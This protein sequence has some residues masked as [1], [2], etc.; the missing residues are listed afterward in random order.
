M[1]E[2]MR[3]KLSLCKD[4]LNAFAKKLKAPS[5]IIK[6]TQG[7]GV[8]EIVLILIIIVGL[9]V[10]FRSNLHEIIANVFNEINSTIAEF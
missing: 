3:N 5:L 10:I 9:I 4:K 1:K 8:I 2:L 6:S 7:I